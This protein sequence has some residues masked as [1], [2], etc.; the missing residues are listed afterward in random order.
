MENG[1]L[2]QN[3]EEIV[4]SLTGLV[5]FDDLDHLVH[6]LRG[7]GFSVDIKFGPSKIRGQPVNRNLLRVTAKKEG[8]GKKA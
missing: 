4:S 8:V 1:K 6:A 5:K 2:K 3:G 7:A